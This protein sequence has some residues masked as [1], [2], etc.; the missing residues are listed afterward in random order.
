MII[1]PNNIVGINTS[2]IE[3][4]TYNVY[5]TQNL[6]NSPSLD[7]EGMAYINTICIY[8]NNLKKKKKLR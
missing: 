4:F 2:S 3:S 7:V 6:T 1:Q 5:G 8:D